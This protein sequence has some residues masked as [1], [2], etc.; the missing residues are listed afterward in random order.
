VNAEGYRANPTGGA[1]VLYVNRGEWAALGGRLGLSLRVGMRYRIIPAEG[2][3]GPW[4]ITTAA[5]S[6]A[7]GDRDGREVFAYHWNPAMPP[8]FPHLHVGARASGD[9]L[10]QNAHLPTGR[11]ALEAVVRLLVTELHVPPLRRDWRAV[12][13][14][15]EDR[16]GAWRT[17]S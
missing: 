15:G 3:R 8:T 14:R 7:V 12:L 5:Y 1:H 9:L 6:Y 13:R 2:A 4:R 11:V 10:V 16:F 17:W